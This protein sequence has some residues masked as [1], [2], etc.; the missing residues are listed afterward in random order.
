[1]VR[2][3]GVRSRGFAGFVFDLVQYVSLKSVVIL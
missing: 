2:I 1:M 3:E